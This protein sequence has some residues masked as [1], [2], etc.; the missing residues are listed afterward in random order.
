MA[1]SHSGTGRGGTSRQ[2]AANVTLFAGVALLL[3]GVLSVLLGV[4]GIARDA[5][6][7]TPPHYEYRFSLTAWGWIHLVIGMALLAASVGILTARSWGR[8]A[9]VA[10]AAASLVSQFMFIPYYPVW[11]ISVMVLDLLA[12]WAL[13]RLVPELDL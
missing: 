9:G 10:L 8:G 12:I 6:Y 2:T 7:G 1:E 13:A 3:S 4:T 5:L 11:S